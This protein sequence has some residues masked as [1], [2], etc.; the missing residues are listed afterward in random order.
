MRIVEETSESPTFATLLALKRLHQAKRARY[1]CSSDANDFRDALKI[2][3]RFRATLQKASERI[4]AMSDPEEKAKALESGNGHEELQHAVQR[5][6]ADLPSSS[7]Q[8]VALSSMDCWYHLYHALHPPNC[9]IDTEDAS[10]TLIDLCKSFFLLFH[11]TKDAS[12]LDAL[13]AYFLDAADFFPVGLP[14]M[15]NRRIVLFT[16]FLLLDDTRH[17]VVSEEED[18]RYI[19]YYK[20]PADRLKLDVS[21][22]EMMLK[23]SVVRLGRYEET[24][25]RYEL[26]VA[27]GLLKYL[28]H[29]PRLDEMCRDSVQEQVTRLAEAYYG[30]LLPDLS[31]LTQAETQDL[32]LS[33]NLEY[34]LLFQSS[35]IG[36]IEQ[37]QSAIGSNSDRKKASLILDKVVQRL[38]LLPSNHP[39]LPNMVNLLAS[40]FVEKYLPD[41]NSDDSDSPTTIQFAL[42][43]LQRISPP[44]PPEYPWL[45]IAGAFQN[46]YDKDQKISHLH[47]ADNILRASSKRFLQ[48]DES[49]SRILHEWA[50][51]RLTLYEE[52]GSLE[53]LEASVDLYKECISVNDEVGIQQPA[54]LSELANALVWT[55]KLEGREPLLDEA[56]ELCRKAK[57]KLEL[58]DDPSNSNSNSAKRI[59]LGNLATCLRA[60]FYTSKGDPGDLKEAVELTTEMA[61]LAQTNSD[62][63]SLASIVHRATIIWSQFDTQGETPYLEE[64]IDILRAAIPQVGDR[65]DLTAQQCFNSYGVCL[66]NQYEREGRPEDLETAT[67]MYE[68]TL[69]LR[70]YG[71]PLRAESLTNLAYC[72][73]NKFRATG[74][75]QHLDES[76]EMYREAIDCR[77]FPHYERRSSLSNLA[78]ALLVRYRFAGSNRLEF[79]DVSEALELARQAA[80]MYKGRHPLRLTALNNVI[81]PL[82]L[83][84]EIKQNKAYLDEA[85][86]IATEVLEG[87]SQPDTTHSDRLS[88]LDQLATLLFKSMVFQHEEGTMQRAIEMQ[89]EVVSSAPSSHPHRSLFYEHLA[90]LLLARYEQSKARPDI[91][92]AT[93]LIEQALE[94]EPSPHLVRGSLLHERVNL[95][96]IRYTECEP[97]N[98]VLLEETMQGYQETVSYQFS[99]PPQRFAVCLMWL[100]FAESTNHPSRLLAHRARL[101]LA[102]EIV[103]LAAGSRKRQ[104]LLLQDGSDGM[105]RAAAVCFI[106]AGRL[107][108][109]VELLELGRAIFWSQMLKLRTPLDRLQLADPSLARKWK[110]VLSALEV[111]FHRD[112]S[113][114]STI[115]DGDDKS[116]L[117]REQEIATVNRLTDSRDKIL[118]EIR[119]LKGFQEF[120]K[121]R[122]F[123][124][125][126]RA[127]ERWPV[128]FL[129]P[130][131]SLSYALV[132]TSYELRKVTLRKASQTRVK[133]LLQSMHVETA[134][135]GG[136][137]DAEV[138]KEM[139]GGRGTDSSSWKSP[140]SAERGFKP[141]SRVHGFKSILKALWVEIVQP[142]FE[143][144]G[145]T[146]N[147]KP[148]ILR[149]CPVGLFGFLPL[150]AAGVYDD[151]SRE[152]DCVSQYVASSYIPAVEVLLQE[153]EKN[154]AILEESMLAVVDKSLPAATMEVDA[155]ERISEK[156]KIR[157][158]KL[159][160]GSYT[161][162][163]TENRTQTI[164]L[165]VI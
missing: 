158:I 143:L 30:K 33:K 73:L 76:I 68:R 148:G 42:Q 131:E 88:S 66:M 163:A 43:T 116:K 115:L 95:L 45:S 71:H 107:E 1:I 59:I 18:T 28:F 103:N 58:T 126:R 119:S 22:V 39:V 120:L 127:A 60:R 32:L 89:T 134:G 155:V 50:T 2:H 140:S 40:V 135:F 145:Y 63:D 124:S 133:A 154:G 105:A 99:S 64:T 48:R 77:P 37:Y 151:A 21:P 138:K 70:K 47:E 150:H 121:P 20:S 157:L 11:I 122:S 15:S 67:T 6:F 137:D 23:A 8:I 130:G 162:H 14:G 81:G 96:Q 4:N 98:G 65:V 52:V 117:H 102:H 153:G 62:G 35:L 128:V 16:H 9:P 101:L 36:L 46:Q 31:L 3:E 53:D 94:L 29:H 156:H 147:E 38:R 97:D 7:L 129:I 93:E 92:E 104:E 24:K 25:E 139:A 123:D 82:L 159:G 144:L 80:G 49:R 100:S 91:L 41:T 142:V 141:L 106:E 61:T 161:L 84:F 56:V 19:T 112:S 55:Y 152:I 78:R 10:S 85:I 54:L 44:S 125:I 34:E 114:S 160:Q 13:M 110:E 79:E 90:V 111:A 118:A 26:N 113:P 136:F 108:E 109:A 51:H 86:E 83:L 164:L 87:R 27:L 72:R 146:K 12:Y 57:L 132:L 165:T 5:F 75:R 69:A 17:S 74:D 149:W